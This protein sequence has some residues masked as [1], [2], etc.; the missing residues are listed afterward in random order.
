MSAEP[1]TVDR[2][3]PR[4]ALDA[5]EIGAKAGLIVRLLDDAAA[6]RA[7]RRHTNAAGLEQLA[8]AEL[9]GLLAALERHFQRFTEAPK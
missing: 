8:R 2:L 9:R 5:L 7:H 4:I 3:T 6:H 1:T